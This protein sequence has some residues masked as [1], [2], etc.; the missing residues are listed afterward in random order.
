[1][2]DGVNDY[3]SIP[4]NADLA[5]GSTWAIEAWINPSYYNAGFNTIY[6]WVL[7]AGCKFLLTVAVI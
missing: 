3:V 5:I 2:F 7:V 1:M 6:S 4:S